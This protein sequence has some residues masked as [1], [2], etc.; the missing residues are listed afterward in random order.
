MLQK[1]PKMDEVAAER[2]SKTIPEKSSIFQEKAK[3][4]TPNNTPQTF[5][6]SNSKLGGIM[7][8]GLFGGWE[9]VMASTGTLRVSWAGRDRFS[10]MIIFW[11]GVGD[12][13]SAKKKRP[14]LWTSFTHRS[15]T[16]RLCRWAPQPAQS[17]P[18]WAGQS[19]QPLGQHAAVAE[20]ADRQRGQRDAVLPAEPP[21]PPLH[22][23]G[24]HHRRGPRRPGP[25]CLPTL[26][27][28]A[29]RPRKCVAKLLQ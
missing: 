6:C 19:P 20:V 14:E 24:P 10:G 13:F 28:W 7:R 15:V 21:H 4:K 1:S 12:E 16:R 8:E 29:I 25:P 22:H 17:A 11:G 9:T 5:G 18:M 23:D 2:M 26:S 3:I 27:G